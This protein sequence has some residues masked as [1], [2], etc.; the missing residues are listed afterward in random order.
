MGKEHH[1]N[2]ASAKCTLHKCD[3]LFMH[4]FVVT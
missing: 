3:A 2:V 1:H 4:R